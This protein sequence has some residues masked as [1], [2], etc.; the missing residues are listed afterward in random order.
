MMKTLKMIFGLLLMANLFG[1]QKDDIE[2]P[3]P[4]GSPVSAAFG[5]DELIAEN[6]A[7]KEIKIQFNKPA[8]AN[9]S[10]AVEVSADLPSSFQT[11]PAIVDGEIE[12]PVTKGSRS[13][14]F[15]ITPVDNNTLD[16]NK[17][18]VFELSLLPEGFQMGTKKSAQVTILDDESPVEAS[19]ASASR[20]LRKDQLEGI[21]VAILLSA[22]APAEGKVSVQLN[23]LAEAA[24]FTTQPA[25]NAAGRL[26]LSVPVGATSTSFTI[27]PANA[28]WD[29][30][31]NVVFSITDTQG[32]IIKG[33]GLS[34]ELALIDAATTALPKSYE[35]V[36]G[37][38]RYKRTY[39][40]DGGGRVKKVH[41]EQETPFFS[42]GTDTYF[43]AQNGL[44]ERVNYRAGKD[45]YFYQENGRIVRSEE[46]ANG[47]MTAYKE[48]DYD[49]AGNVGASDT[50]YRQPD[51][52]YAKSLIFVY[53]Y[54]AEGNIYKQL[55]Y[56]PTAGSGEPSLNSTRTF[57]GYSNIASP[58][59]M[60]EI[61]P[62]VIAQPNLPASYRVEENGADLLYHFSYDFREDGLPVRRHTSGA[63]SEVT[64]YEYY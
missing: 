58:F 40:Y 1:C 46:I 30:N 4:A 41:W 15:T 14:S 25:L 23:N 19:F 57:E 28:N 3:P 18:I 10:I 39:E 6:S 44:I 31:K 34:L 37:N 36:G 35:T 32:G 29:G 12:I 54:Q 20:T 24:L 42:Q 27:K 53:L 17:A 49:A 62:G 16:G 47:V 7:A 63:G 21:S 55:T 33:N 59:P 11:T 26:E 56:I 45:E 48:Y 5:A 2:V 52:T 64:T 13:A 60:I 9:G 61:I 43:Y 22:P 50:Y 38:W 51:G 8:P